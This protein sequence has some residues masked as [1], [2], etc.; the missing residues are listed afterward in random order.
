MK[1]GSVGLFDFYEI[2]ARSI[3]K[4]TTE[5]N[6]LCWPN[7]YVDVTFFCL[8]VSALPVVTRQNVLNIRLLIH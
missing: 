5:I 7:L 8:S 3:R 6:D 4:V 2:Y 1:V